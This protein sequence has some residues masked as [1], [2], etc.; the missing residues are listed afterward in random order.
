[1]YFLTDPK[2]CRQRTSEEKKKDLD[3]LCKQIRELAALDC[4]FGGGNLHIVLE[5][6]NLEDSHILFCILSCVKAGDLVGLE[7]LLLIAQLTGKERELMY[8]M[9]WQGTL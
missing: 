7:L 1:M 9:E 8:I 5:D 6:G 4:F 2:E 3:E